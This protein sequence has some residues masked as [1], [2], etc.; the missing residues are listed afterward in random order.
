MATSSPLAAYAFV[1][2]RYSPTG[3]PAGQ[4]L[5]PAQRRCAAVLRERR[6]EDVPT[7]GDGAR[8]AVLAAVQQ[9]GISLADASEKLRADHV[10]VSTAVQQYG[11]ALKYA[12][13]ELHAERK[14]VLAAVQEYGGALQYASK[15]L[16]ADHEIVLAAAQLRDTH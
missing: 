14:V 16:R 15:E 11:D 9:K 1:A 13:E 4:P 5:C 10:I 7:D 12:S 8:E 6:C 3:A 2:R